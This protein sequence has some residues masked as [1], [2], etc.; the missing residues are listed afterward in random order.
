[1]GMWCMGNDRSGGA[2]VSRGSSEPVNFAT[3]TDLDYPDGQF[4]ILYRI[5]DSVVPLT[6]AVFFLAGEL[7]APCRAG[8][9]GKVSDTLDDPLQIVPGDGC[10]IL[11]DRIF[12]KNAIGGHWP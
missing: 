9:F 8:I 1:M 11:P 2:D 3:V 5:D 10:K 6:N 4:E 7:F 12:E